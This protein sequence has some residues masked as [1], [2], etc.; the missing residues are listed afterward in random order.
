MT[1]TITIDNIISSISLILVTISTLR[2]ASRLEHR[3]NNHGSL[4]LMDGPPILG[5]TIVR[6]T[7]QSEVVKKQQREGGTNNELDDNCRIKDTIN[8][9]DGQD[10]TIIEASPLWEHTEA[11]RRAVI[12]GL[13][14]DND[15]ISNSDVSDSGSIFSNIIR[16]DKEKSINN[17]RGSSN[18]NSVDDL[19][20][21]GLIIP[22]STRDIVE[23]GRRSFSPRRLVRGGFQK[24]SKATTSK[25]KESNNNKNPI[26][27][28]T[29]WFILSRWRIQSSIPS[30]IASTLRLFI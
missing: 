25:D 9:E 7:P 27:K 24:K 20:A 18:D 19:A 12:L 26:N 11:F 10:T 2:A 28:M 6:H 22:N 4:G 15:N 3:L 16:N 23:R 13:I 5:P 8:I 1:P 30:V 14:F 17:V 29:S 21:A